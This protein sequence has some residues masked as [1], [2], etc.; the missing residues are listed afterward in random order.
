MW[1][2]ESVALPLP[3]LALRICKRSGMGV[4]KCAGFQD[5]Q[6]EAEQVLLSFEAHYGFQST[7]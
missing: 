3:I 4:E 2:R 5:E 1:S 7:K 6:L